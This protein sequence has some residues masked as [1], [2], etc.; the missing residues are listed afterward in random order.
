MHIYFPKIPRSKLNM[1]AYFSSAS[2]FLS[3]SPSKEANTWYCSMVRFNPFFPGNNYHQS[4]NIKVQ[5]IQ[6]LPVLLI[7]FTKSNIRLPPESTNSNPFL[8]SQ[9]PSYDIF[10]LKRGSWLLC[11]ISRYPTTMGYTAF[12]AFS[13]SASLSI[14]ELSSTM[15]SSSSTRFD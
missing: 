4:P 10:I 7:I 6:Y 1:T 12:S 15:S 13:A 11:S 3:I 8:P 2:N 14:S 9:F 5:E